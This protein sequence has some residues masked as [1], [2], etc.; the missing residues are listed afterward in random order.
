MKF[1]KSIFASVFLCFVLLG[2]VAVS[3]QDEPINLRY[4]LWIAADSP[5]VARF[6]EIAAAYTAEHPNVTI[7]FESIPFGDYQTDVTLQL[8]GSNPPDAGWIVEGAARLWV[9]SGVL[10]DLG[11][12]LSADDSYNIGDFSESSLSLW[13]EGDAVYGIPFST[14]PFI[15]LYN[16]DLFEAA[17]TPTPDELL[18]TGEW[19]WES[20]AAAAKAIADN[21]EAYGFQSND[22]AL[23]TGNFWATLIPI[24]RGFGGDSWSPDNMCLF[25]SPG[26]VAG[27]Q[28]LHDMIFVDESMVP[29]G[30][31][32]DFY[33]GNA[34]M[35][36]GQLSRVNRL[37]EASFEWSIAPLPT[38]VNGTQSVIGQAAMVVFNNSQNR[39]AAIDFVRYMTT[40]ENVARIAQFFPPARE[41]VLNSDALVEANPLI[42][43]ELMQSA[44]IDA[45][46]NGVVLPSSAQFPRIEF[47]VRPALDEMWVAD[48]D[49]QAITTSICDQINPLLAR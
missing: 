45:I 28:Y 17:G 6:N 15:V 23:Y 47:L 24:M 42:P 2:V 10:T 19:T 4:T 12:T 5:Q 8:S 27:L 29:P 30:T 32:V 43:A 38:G 11:P 21:T 13:S 33:A 36:M 22:A 35:T 37:A 20:F 16:R 25:N 31:E 7:T 9:G 49:I 26:S 40:Q 1:R 48:A 3:A 18:A 44:V 39:D 14:S 34:G 46:Q 41:S